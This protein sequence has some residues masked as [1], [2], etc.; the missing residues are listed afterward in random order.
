MF[1]KEPFVIGCND[2][3][4]ADGIAA[5]RRKQ[6]PGLPAMGAASQRRNDVEVERQHWAF[7]KDS[8]FK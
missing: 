7:F 2:I 3:D 5:M 1:K 4:R 6:A 8:E